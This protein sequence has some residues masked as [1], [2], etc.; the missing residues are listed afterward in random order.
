MTRE[1]DTLARRRQ[2]IQKRIDESPTTPDPSLYHQLGD[3]HAEMGERKEALAAYGR[4]IDGF[5]MSARAQVAMAICTKVIRRYPGVTRTHFTLA[6][7]A[8]FIG[9]M[10]DGLDA[11]ENY[12]DS[13]LASS[14]VGMAIP[15]LRFMAGLMLDRNVRRRIG[16]LLERMGDDEADRVR[17]GDPPSSA[18]AL[19]TEQRGEL[20]LDLARW[21]SETVWS[22]Y[23]L[24]S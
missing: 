23:W 24:P 8:M 9:R 15:R 17:I 16:D 4:A 1:N 3:V 12:V 20:L 10:E 18:A 2:A 7:T 19:T 14:T 11:L 21:G 22:G 6:C 13:A 5:L